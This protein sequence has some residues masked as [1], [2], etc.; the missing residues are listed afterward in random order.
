MDGYKTTI[1][2]TDLRDAEAFL[3]GFLKE[4]VPEGNYEA[5][6]AIRDL[7][8]TGFATMYAFLRGEVDRVSA[9]QSLLRIQE[10]LTDEEDI[11]QSVNEILSNWF[12]TRKGGTYVTVSARVHLQR[13]IPRTISV[14]SEFFKTAAQKFVLNTDGT[15]F[16]IS[17][18]AQFP[19]YDTKGQLVEYVADIPLRASAPGAS[20]K[21]EPGRFMRVVAPIGLSDLIYAETVV[22]S[23]GG[24]DVESTDQLLQRAD[25]VISV[26][27][28][29]N[30]RS[31]DVTLQNEFPLIEETMT[32]GMGEPE[33]VRDVPKELG[34]HMLLHVGGCYDTYVTLPRTSVTEMC[35][36][37]GYFPRADGLIN[38]FRD[39][40]LTYETGYDYV[41]L[42]VKVGYVLK[43]KSGLVNSPQEYLI[44]SVSAHELTVSDSNPFP[45]VSDTTQTITYSIGYLPP[46][47]E[48]IN[49]TPGDPPTVTRIAA[50][51][52]DY[53]EVPYGTSNLTHQ[54]GKV[55]LTGPILDVTWVEMLDAPAGSTMADP[56]TGKIVFVTRVNGTPVNTTTTVPSDTQYQLQVTNPEKAQSLAAINLLNLGTQVAAFDGKKLQVTYESLQGFAPIHSYVVSRSR[57]TA[58]AN[59]LVRSRHPVWINFQV[60]YKLQEGTTLDTDT[61][62]VGLTDYINAFNDNLMLDSSDITT[63]LRSTYA[64][65]STMYPV[66]LR[67][68][69]N[70]P[71]GQQAMFESTDIVSIFPVEDQS[72]G[73]T[74]SNGSDLVTPAELLA[75]GKILS[76]NI[77]TVAELNTWYNWMGITDRTTSYKTRADLITFVL[78]Y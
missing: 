19:V 27:N 7:M 67:F 68:T 51:H 6:S 63:F 17:E 26:R 20:Y 3:V 43:V 59:H 18:D 13:R 23:E 47:Y 5:G 16:A 74:L 46:D 4:K 40:G 32:V 53:P 58:V 39:P 65:I 37:G 75:N 33:M 22:S 50:A 21:T 38:T 31:C 56:I 60:D 12:V 1:S 45:V 69:L 11:K 62:A 64:Q 34:A 29:V 8:V 78:R 48:N 44:T 76:G 57:R 72:N 41:T 25:T 14:R 36:V 55:A 66:T 70:A 35:T 2:Q 54:P 61:A 30:N 77:D 15:D 42:G 10:E 49:F 52:V 9:R 24:N 28:L 71:D 73:V